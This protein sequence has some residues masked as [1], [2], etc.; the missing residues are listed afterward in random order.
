MFST[1]STAPS[2]A[3]QAPVAISAFS[4]QTSV[5]G[6]VI[7]K[8]YGTNR[9]PGNILDFQ[10]FLATAVT[11]VTQNP[12]GSSGGGKGGGGSQSTSTSTTTF[13][14]SA[15]VQIALCS[16]P[17]AGIGKVWQDKS[18]TSLANLGLTLFEGDPI[19]LP[20]AYNSV[21]HPDHAL[22]YDYLAYVADATY[23]LTTSASI[24]NN[25]FEIICQNL[26]NGLDSN[27]A[28][29]ALD[30]LTNPM[31]GC[32]FPPGNIG[33]LGNYSTYCLATGILLSPVADSQAQARQFLDD[34]ATITNS[35]WVWS[36]N[37]LNIVPYGDSVISGNG[38]TFAPNMTPLFDL[39]DDDF[40]AQPNTDPVI[41]TRANL[42]DCYN[43]V[44]LEIVDRSTD[45]NVV[46]VSVEDQNSVE[47]FGLIPGASLQAHSITSLALGNY[48]AQLMLQRSVY[49]L[50]NHAFTVGWKFG[51]LDPM[52]LVTLT[53]GPSMFRKLVR[54]KTI[55]EDQNGNLAMTAEELFVGLAHAPVYGSQARMGRIGDNNIAPPTSNPPFLITMP[56]LEI[57]VAASGPPGWG[58]CSVWIS[59]DNL[60]YK[61]V[62]KI[63]GSSR[64]G[65]LT[66]FVPQGVDPDL[67]NSVNVDLSISNG[68]MLS[69]TQDDADLANTLCVINNEFIS[70]ETAT[71]I[72]ANKYS[73][74]TYLRRGVYGTV[75]TTHFAGEQFAVVDQG[76]GKIP[77]LISQ[78]GT[79]VFVKLTA[80]NNFEAAEE[81]LSD[82]E[83]TTFVVPA[84][85]PPGIIQNFHVLQS[86]DVIVF[87]WSD[88]PVFDISV[89]LKG[90]DL[91]Y[92]PVGG[93]A[94]HSTLITEASRSTETTTAAVPPGVWVFYIRGHDY[95]EQLGPASS[96]VLNVIAG[97]ISILYFEAVA[98]D[99]AD[100]ATNTSSGFYRHYTGVLC[101]MGTLATSSYSS[102]NEFAIWCPDPVT[103]AIY[104]TDAADLTFDDT[105]RLYTNP[106]VFSLGPNGTG[107]P[108]VIFEKD[109]WLSAGADAGTF[110]TWTSGSLTA[111][112]VR[113]RIKETP[114][115]SPA[116][117]SAF[118][119]TIDKTPNDQ[120]S[121]G[122]I[123]V[124]AGG[125]PVNFPIPYHFLP[126]VV[127]A[128]TGSNVAWV[129][130]V[131]TTS[132]I[133][134]V[135]P[136]ITTDTGG[137]A[138]WHAFGV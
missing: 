62:T 64:M 2:T 126:S 61:K 36:Q 26:A 135:G 18:L 105:F 41:T 42:A 133:L 85:V 16:G 13:T 127:P 73:L 128:A 49:V 83:P 82:V 87:S 3:S 131:T 123:A 114:G 91:S 45:Y 51:K 9:V 92:G 104:E 30:W 53:D 14:Y 120:T 12:G 8:V 130:S 11:T 32:G 125:T 4:V 38:V 108:T 50:N 52:D 68:I 58:G 98:P 102:F 56:G 47:L 6:I 55:A 107:T 37:L 129:T 96:A 93:D 124:S 23:Q 109:S 63:I 90:Y 89:G 43:N 81:Q 33:N 103:T 1:A 27:P 46:P 66:N 77:Y 39:T 29:I 138:S 97:N 100:N 70:Y 111:R 24:Q 69:G 60:K 28:F 15:A 5:Y 17:I 78:I 74:T 115:S 48:V 86:G 19:Q 136:N 122:F 95:A 99:W 118:S 101:P 22:Q 65:T 121:T 44:T 80:F 119:P 72:G 117:I 34:L 132:F 25:S 31:D 71:L 10:D 88:L 20:W 112:F 7:P 79:T 59:I 40:I 113:M 67:V 106:L 137:S 75:D 35:E 94:D 110:S 134:H 54:I 116:M 84:P 76:I 21:N 57:G